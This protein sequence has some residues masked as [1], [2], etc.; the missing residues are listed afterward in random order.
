MVLWRTRRAVRSKGG[1]EVVVGGTCTRASMLEKA[2]RGF[3]A[4]RR[5]RHRRVLWS[6]APA[7]CARWRS[8]LLSR[9]GQIVATP[10]QGKVSW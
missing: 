2:W 10:G 5:E 1:V 3:D 7:P 4:T 8:A 6:K 9:D